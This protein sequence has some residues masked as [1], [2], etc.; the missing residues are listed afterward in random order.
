MAFPRSRPW[1]A[2]IDT[3]AMYIGFS[4]VSVQPRHNKTARRQ[5]WRGGPKALKG[6][7]R[8][9]IQQHGDAGQDEDRPERTERGEAKERRTDSPAG[10]KPGPESG[11][12]SRREEEKK[13]CSYGG[14]G[15][16]HY[17]GSICHPPSRK[18]ASS[19][20]PTSRS[21]ASARGWNSVMREGACA[22]VVTIN[23]MSRPRQRRRIHGLG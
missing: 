5:D 15:A 6:E 4:E 20:Q 8:K 3:T 21:S 22:S 11:D 7:P 1:P 19:V 18:T 13:G 14:R 16:F 10:K 12:C 17:I 9:R 2:T 23:G